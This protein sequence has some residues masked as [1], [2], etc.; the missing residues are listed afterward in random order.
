MA[1]PPGISVGVRKTPFANYRNIPAIRKVGPCSG[2]Q[3]FVRED[4]VFAQFFNA[5][6]WIMVAAD[7][8]PPLPHRSARR[9][10]RTFRHG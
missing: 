3:F 2:F 1:T 8:Q 7:T 9:V 5:A 6:L 10:I 4:H